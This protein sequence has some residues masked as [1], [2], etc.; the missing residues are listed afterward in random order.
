MADDELENNETVANQD[1]VSFWTIQI[2]QLDRP[3]VNI[4][5]VNPE[6]TV[7]DFKKQVTE[8]VGINHDLQ[9]MIYLGRVLEN[10]KTLKDY[11][12]F[13]SCCVHLL[14]KTQNSS[15]SNSTTLQTQT[16]RFSR[17]TEN[18]QTLRAINTSEIYRTLQQQ[19]SRNNRGV[20][21]RL[22]RNF[23]AGDNVEH[24]YQGIATLHTLN[25]HFEQR[26]S[27]LV[28]QEKYESDDVDVIDNIIHSIDEQEVDLRSHEIK[29]SLRLFD[30]DFIE[31]KI[32][33][34]GSADLQYGME[35]PPSREQREFQVGQWIGNIS[36]LFNKFRLSGHS[37]P[38]VR[39]Y[40]YI[41]F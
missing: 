6:G 31:E 24:I 3:T 2:K 30:E 21:R 5:E 39:S 41:Y 23:A 40:Y 35:N 14:K 29:E 32:N 36:F 27:G 8:A 17:T 15:T 38:M 12:M 22:G 4:G 16:R 9:R 1:D 33:S 11:S 13:D 34:S 37:K 7:L 18:T 20:S 19:L 25:S 28:A 26:R 10:S